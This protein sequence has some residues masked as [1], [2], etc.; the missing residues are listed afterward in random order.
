MDKTC[1]MS[2]RTPKTQKHELQAPQFAKQTITFPNQIGQP[3]HPFG[4]L[5]VDAAWVLSN[6]NCDD[7][8]PGRSTTQQPNTTDKELLGGQCRSI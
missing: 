6:K 2:F 3:F 5:V 4:W 1:T 7:F 8:F